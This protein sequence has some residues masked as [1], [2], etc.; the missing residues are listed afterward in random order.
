[1]GVGLPAAK[2]LRLMKDEARH[3]SSRE[4]RSRIGKPGS[5]RIVFRSSVSSLSSEEKGPTA[6]VVL[7]TAAYRVVCFGKTGKP[8]DIRGNAVSL[9]GTRPLRERS[10]RWSKH[11]Q[12]HVDR[13]ATVFRSICVIVGP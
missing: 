3:D 5:L 13:S 6:M 11:I 2:F 10:N 1:M 4:T 12:K 8:R 9:Q 7:V